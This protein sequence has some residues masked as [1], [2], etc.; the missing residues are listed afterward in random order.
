ME[1]MMKMRNKN[2][3]KVLPP[4]NRLRPMPPRPNTNTNTNP[5]DNIKEEKPSDNRNIKEPNPIMREEPNL[6]KI[7]V[8]TVETGKTK[9]TVDITEVTRKEE[10]DIKEVT[11]V[12]TEVETE[13]ETEVVEEDSVIEE[14]AEASVIEEAEE[15]SVIEEAVEASETEEEAEEASITEEVDLSTKTE[16]DLS[17]FKLS[18][19]PTL[20]DI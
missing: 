1:K 17:I 2:R 14:V 12:A 3:I 10:V 4:L 13:V 18:I 20:S 6:G 15:D 5:K 11:E 7:E 8:K 19:H 16:N 9:N